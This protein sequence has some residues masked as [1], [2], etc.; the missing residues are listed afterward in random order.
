[1]FQPQQYR[2]TPTAGPQQV[3]VRRP[4]Q[5]QQQQQQQ[6][7]RK[8]QLQQQGGQRYSKFP[9]Q[10]LTVSFKHLTKPLST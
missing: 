3:L 9:Q 6:D 1:M 4:Q 10:Q 8:P 5:Q 2:N 7:Y